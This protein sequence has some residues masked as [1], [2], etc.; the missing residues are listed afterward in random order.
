MKGPGD[1]SEVVGSPQAGGCPFL[2]GLCECLQTR[3][4]LLCAFSILEQEI[5][6]LTNSLN[7]NLLLKYVKYSSYFSCYYRNLKKKSVKQ[8]GLLN[9]V[10][11]TK[12]FSL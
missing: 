5:R 2:R 8:I 4:T 7:H 3:N 12:N 11:F 6:I 9:L 10:V 1:P